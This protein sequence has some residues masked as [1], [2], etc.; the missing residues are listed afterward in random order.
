MTASLS[1]CSSPRKKVA[2]YLDELARCRFVAVLDLFH[3][4]AGV[5]VVIQRLLFLSKH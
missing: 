4:G 3:T 2:A 1:V 5:E